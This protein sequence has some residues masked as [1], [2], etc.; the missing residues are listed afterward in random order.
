MRSYPLSFVLGGRC[1]WGESKLYVQGSGGS[2][3]TATLYTN[4]RGYRMYLQAS[5]V[6]TA[7][8]NTKPS[9]YSVRQGAFN[10]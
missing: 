2:W 9:G 7:S 4:E 10:E 5:S 1:H 3:W 8:S 6:S